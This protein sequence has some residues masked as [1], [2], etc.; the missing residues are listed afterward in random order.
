MPVYNPPKLKNK[1]DEKTGHFLC[2]TCGRE[3]G[4]GVIIK[5]YVYCRKCGREKQ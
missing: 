1:I 2:T 5:G 4:I 3:V